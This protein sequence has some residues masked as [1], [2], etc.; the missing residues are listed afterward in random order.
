MFQP[1]RHSA[2]APCRALCGQNGNVNGSSCRAITHRGGRCIALSGA[3]GSK[4]SGFECMR[5]GWRRCV[6]GSASWSGHRRPL[7]IRSLPRRHRKG[8]PR[9]CAA[10]KEVRGL[11]RLIAVDASGLAWAVAVI[12]ANVRDWTER[13][14]L[15]GLATVAHWIQ[16]IF[17]DGA[18]SGILL[19]WVRYMVYMR[20]R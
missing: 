9:L 18:N 6:G 5:S 4:A 11:Q 16:V 1:A 12:S 14:L 7:W 20:F 10:G 8:E 19:D 3:G 17:A 15:L 13:Y 2:D